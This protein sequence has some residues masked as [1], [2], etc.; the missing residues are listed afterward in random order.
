[1][2]TS[3]G[4]VDLIISLIWGGRFRGS[5][6]V[7][8]KAYACRLGF[9]DPDMPVKNGGVREEQLEGRNRYCRGDSAKVEDALVLKELEV[10]ED[11]G[12]MPQ[13]VE[14]HLTLRPRCAL[15]DVWVG[16]VHLVHLVEAVL[17]PNLTGPKETPLVDILAIVTD[18][19]G[20]LEEE[21]HGVG[22]L[23]LDAEPGGFFTRSGENAGEALADEA[24]GVVAVEVVLCDGGK[25]DGVSCRGSVGVVGHTE[26]HFA[27]DV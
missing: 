16:A 21:T 4:F 7:G 11:V 8:D 9:P 5:S 1:M 22:K 19:A 27:A 15:S 26:P 13:R 14:D 3:R 2:A 6:R 17:T 18:D 20:F 12:R 10:V 25:V 23:E 24:G